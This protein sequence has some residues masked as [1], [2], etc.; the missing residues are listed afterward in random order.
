MSAKRASQAGTSWMWCR[1]KWFTTII[2]KAIATCRST[3]SRPR[4]PRRIPAPGP[5]VSSAPSWGISSRRSPPPNSS[6]CRRTPSRTAPLP[7]S[8][9][10]CY[11]CDPT[12][13]SGCPDN[14]SCPPTRAPSGSISKP[15][16]FCESRCRPKKFQRRSRRLRLKPQ[17][18]TTPSAWGQPDKFLLPV[19]AEALSC[20]RNSNECQRNVIE[21]R[22]YHKFEGESII[23]FDQEQK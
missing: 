4:N 7:S 22:N 17:W 15:R 1:P 16:K 2:R 8:T 11:G 13:R 6:T 14:M 3:E 9:S 10:K 23:K 12:G 18:T 19:H 5:R 21:F 20:W